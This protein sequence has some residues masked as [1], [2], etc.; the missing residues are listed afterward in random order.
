MYHRDHC[1]EES[2]V[3]QWG[4]VNHKI[5]T[6]L[7]CTEKKKKQTH[8]WKQDFPL[9]FFVHCGFTLAAEKVLYSVDSPKQMANND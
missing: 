4:G 8:S 5:F 2:A 7:V 1:P 3:K 9:V 6:I